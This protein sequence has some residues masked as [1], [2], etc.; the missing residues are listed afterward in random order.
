M[1]ETTHRDNNIK[2]YKKVGWF[3]ARHSLTFALGAAALNLDRILDRVLWPGE[4]E[5]WLKMIAIA[6]GQ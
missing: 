2:K 1:A 4:W 5:R 6:F 3:I